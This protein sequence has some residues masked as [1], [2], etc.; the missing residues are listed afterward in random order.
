MA[1][2]QRKGRKTFN[3]PLHVT[4]GNRTKEVSAFSNHGG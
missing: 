1:E 4:I 3:A 2:P